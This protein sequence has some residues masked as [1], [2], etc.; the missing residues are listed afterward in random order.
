[1]IE[2]LETTEA[3]MVEFALLMIL[4]VLWFRVRA[5][6][7]AMNATQATNKYHKMRRMGRAAKQ[8]GSY[9]AAWD[10][11]K[12]TLTLVLYSPPMYGFRR[13]KKR[14][15]SSVME[16]DNLLINVPV[17]QIE[18]YAKRRRAAER[19]GKGAGAKRK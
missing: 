18:E 17:K 11:H 19:R 3:V 16:L 9:S 4:I 6:G 7:K 15:L 10:K 12:R 2:I 14:F 1:M 13:N 8:G 5:G